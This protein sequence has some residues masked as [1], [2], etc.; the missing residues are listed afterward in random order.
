[1]N[2]IASDEAET[3]SDNHVLHRL[4]LPVSI[5]KIERLYEGETFGSSLKSLRKKTESALGQAASHWCHGTG[6]IE[7]SIYGRQSWL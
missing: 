2:E 1:M 6:W 4:R 7:D 3:T 5:R